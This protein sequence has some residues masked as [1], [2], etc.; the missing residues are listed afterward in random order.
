MTERLFDGLKVIDAA[1]FIAGPVAATVLADFG[2]DVIKVESPTGDGIRMISKMPGMPVDNR[3]Y[4]SQVDNRSKR[5]ICV[6]L[7]AP[8]GRAVLDRLLA[9]ADVLITNFIPRVREKLGLRYEDL[10]PKFPRLIYA[11]MTAYGEEGPEAEKTGFDATALWARSGLMDLVKPAPDAPPARSLPGMGDHPAGLALLSAI[12]MAIIKRGR[13]GQGSKVSSS[14]VATGIWMN[15]FYGQAALNGA[16]IPPRPSREN[17]IN[18]LGN[19][20]RCADGRWFNLAIVNQDREAPPFFK[21][22]GREDLLADPRFVDPAARRT[23]ATALREILD[24]VFAAQPWSH[25]AEAFKSGGVTVGTVAKITD[26]AEDTQLR[27]AGAV[28]DGASGPTIGSPIFLDGEEKLDPVAAPEPGGDTKTILAELGYNDDQIKEML[29][30]GTVVA[31]K[32]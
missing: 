28:I 7:S 26:L 13:T 3:D 1:S 24:D 12:L 11:S 32:F 21:T 17:T 19:I 31:P 5:S 25:W 30:A 2:A 8:E 9:D 6:D 29:A 23:N 15:A 27:H 20:Y 4:A 14:L 22:I 16:E 10:A 18:P